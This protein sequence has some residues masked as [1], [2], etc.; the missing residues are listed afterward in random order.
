MRR[1][2]LSFLQLRSRHD[3]LAPASAEQEPG[4]PSIQ[5]GRS[6]PDPTSPPEGSLR[7][8]LWLRVAFR[9]CL[10]FFSIIL[11]YPVVGW[12]WEVPSFM[13]ITRAVYPRYFQ[14][15]SWIYGMEIKPGT[16]AEFGIFMLSAIIVASAVTL[17]WS[18]LDR[19]RPHYRQAY[20]RC[21]VFLRY[22]LAFFMLFYGALKLLPVQFSTPPLSALITP[23]GEFSRRDLLWN[24]MGASIAYTVFT[25]LIEFGGGLLLFWRRTATLG[26]LILAGAL[27]NVMVL[28][29]G[30]DIGVKIS[31]TSFLLVALV[32]LAPDARRLTDVLLFNRPVPPARLGGIVQLQQ[33]Q[34]VTTS[35]KAL[36]V[37]SMVSWCLH[38][39]WNA[40]FKYGNGSP[41]PPLYG[42]YNVEDFHSNSA[43]EKTTEGATSSWSRIALAE[44]SI[45]AIEPMRGPVQHFS[46]EADTIARVLTL[47]PWKNAPHPVTLRYTRQADGQLQ[48]TGTAGQDS[49]RMRLRPIGLTD[50]RLRQPNQ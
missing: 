32:L 39:A 26:A 19:E 44:Y 33:A 15:L 16:I 1:T 2:L 31:S 9:F 37:L 3:V 47:S 27:A 36:I 35:L 25:G 17:L 13:P 40:Y 18:V 46:V 12:G 8:P 42:L 30:Y 50:I 28:N 20:A 22:Y 41:L 6:D 21:H 5:L 43:A 4:L 45:A 38:H 29:F 14:A 49:V 23:L 11:L 10:A 34:R 7:W 48:I 24:S